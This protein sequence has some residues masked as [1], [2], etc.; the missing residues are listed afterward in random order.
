MNRI[1]TLGFITMLM[2]GGVFLA[3]GCVEKK[4]PAQRAG[5][6]IDR[7]VENMKDAIDP[8]GPAEKAGRRVDRAVDD[9]TQ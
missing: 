1:A 5:E 3:T 6:Q 8:P 4:G 7:T 9:L 2:T